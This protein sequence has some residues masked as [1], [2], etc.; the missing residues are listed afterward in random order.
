MEDM[1]ASELLVAEAKQNQTRLILEIVKE[2]E[3]KE[4]MIDKIKALLK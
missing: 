1:N 2:S 4:E 3:T